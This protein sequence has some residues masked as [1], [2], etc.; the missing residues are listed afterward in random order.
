M[1]LLLI[2]LLALSLAIPGASAHSQGSPGVRLVGAAAVSPADY[3][4]ELKRFLGWL[5]VRG[6]SL[7]PRQIQ[8]AAEQAYYLA[9]SAAKTHY[10][11]TGVLFPA[12]DTLGLADLF[13]RASRL[14]VIGAEMVSEVLSRPESDSATSVSLPGG[15]L[16]LGFDAPMYTLRSQRGWALRFPFY[17]MIGHAGTAIPANNIPTETVVLSTLFGAHEGAPGQSQ[18]TI[19][20]NVAEHADST[21]FSAF[22][23]EAL[24][25]RASDRVA[26]SLLPGSTTYRGSVAGG[27]MQ[28]DVVVANRGAL[29]F[30]FSYIGLPGTFQ[31][32][33]AEFL[34]LLHSLSIEP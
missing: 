7:P 21:A 32:N 16:S 17:M 22:W 2:A 29:T 8:V 6:D 4:H 25:L 34:A 30:V 24:Q 14:G 5:A 33:R 27:T 31:A 12:R 18:A 19:L 15:T 13:A 3:E 20:L 28:A 9:G 10:Q 26:E 23:L 11:Q 1:H